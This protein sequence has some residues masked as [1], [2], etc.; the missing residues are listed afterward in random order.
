MKLNQIGTKLCW[1]STQW[2]NIEV[3]DFGIKVTDCI[4]GGNR[5]AL[6]VSEH[7]NNMCE[8]LF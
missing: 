8:I 1:K 7:W 6:T 2:P 5:N 4:P 3:L